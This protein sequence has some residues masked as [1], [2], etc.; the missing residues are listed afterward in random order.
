M[1]DDVGSRIRSGVPDLSVRRLFDAIHVPSDWVQQVRE[2]A[3]RGTVVYVL[4]NRSAIDLFA[5]DHL[6]RRHGLPQIG[7]VNDLR[8]GPLHPAGGGLKGLFSRRDQVGELRATL[9]AFGSAA[10]F[11]KR[12]PTALDWVAGAATGGRGLRE[13]DELLPALFACQRDQE[14]PVFLVPQVFVWSRRPDSRGTELFDGLLGPREWP[15]QVR[16]WAQFM[17][18]HQRVELR[19][20]AALDLQAFLAAESAASDDVLVRR[21]VFSVLRRLERERRAVTGPARMPPDRVRARVLRSPKLQQVIGRM[22]GN[23]PDG[24]LALTAQA[25]ATLRRMQALPNSTTLQGIGLVLDRL[26]RSVY[27]GVD[28]DVDGL[29]AVQEASKEHTLVLLPSHRSHL[30]YLLVSYVFERHNLGL[31]L[32]AA[33]DNLAFFPAGPIARRAGAFFI[34]RSFRGDKLYAATAEAYVR[35]LLRDGHT[36]EVFLEGGRSRTGKLLTPQVGLLSVIVDAALT[37][38][39]RPVALVPI[40]IGY[41]RIIEAESYDRETSGAD[42]RPEDAA[43]L[44]RST[45]LLRHRYG[46][47]NLQVGEILPLASLAEELG[48]DLAATRGDRARIKPAK[49]RALVNHAAGRALDEVNRVTAVS[50]GA[51][52]ALALMS[53]E[54]RSVLER[55]LLDRC[56]HLYSVLRAL[57]ARV[58]PACQQGAG[59]NH[60][61]V[62]EAVQM[63]VDGQMVT[64]HGDSSAPALA[65]SEL[66]QAVY[67]EVPEDR[68][69][70]L[71]TAKNHIVHFFVDRAIAATVVLAEAEGTSLEVAQARAVQLGKLFSHEFRLGARDLDGHFAQILRDMVARGE[72]REQAGMLL[73]GEGH[74]GW[75]GLSWLR[76]YRAIVRAFFEGY[77]IAARSLLRLLKGPMPVGEL[78]KR[79]IG[80]GQ[81]MYLTDEV[82]LR[83][84]ANRAI[85]VNAY[86]AFRDEGYLRGRGDKYELTKSFASEGA[87]RAIEG[88][89]AFYLG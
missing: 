5:L 35:R 10:L 57:D 87:V 6:T 61:A 21:L 32:I 50:P 55:D 28:V 49:R 47:A 22:A 69:T 26:F 77:R 76:T 24:R 36:L 78:A 8:L 65:P 46:R 86:L 41:E 71:A 13:A 15:S 20:G 44:L 29:K 11:L 23:K 12:P 60:G 72:L 83:E 7:F 75:S 59:L 88:R 56:E 1:P 9:H 79:A 73:P 70:Q 62:R 37:M 16:T 4:R 82:R 30:D 52:T 84:S 34:R 74:L 67:Y 39:A 2:L 48:I 27:A 54:R 51:L 33:G 85:I 63:L 3:A 89:I 31:P 19:V 14:T 64:R 80:T 43:A 68:R 25:D 38:P 53:D 66:G 45:E 58:T 81:R 17:L 42:K 40:S 18:N